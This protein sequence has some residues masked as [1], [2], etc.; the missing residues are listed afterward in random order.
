MDAT[1]L[2]ILGSAVGGAVGGLAQTVVAASIDWSRAKY[3]GHPPAAG[4]KAVE[5][6]RDF[7]E[8]LIACVQRME[9]SNTATHQQIAKAMYHPNY[10]VVMQQAILGASQTESRDT[11]ILLAAI[12][13]ERL[14]IDEDTT[15]ARVIPHACEVV[16]AL[17]GRQLKLLGLLYTLQHMQLS[18]IPTTVPVDTQKT[19]GL[20]SVQNVLALY[21]DVDC[22]Q[23]DWMNLTS[24]GCL[25]ARPG[26]LVSQTLE[27]MLRNATSPEFSFDRFYMTELGAHL[28]S[29]FDSMLNGMHLTATGSL[30]GL[31]VSDQLAHRMT[32]LAKW[33]G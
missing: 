31:F 23:L 12:V 25:I 4:A 22:K 2:V 7:L 28:R 18:P 6:T 11:H 5:N 8:E 3:A 14:R 21:H 32:N 19:M 13:S 15:A 27:T 1:E 30:I 33:E 9:Q 26:M 10:S 24:E 29:I 20:L 16:T 17:T